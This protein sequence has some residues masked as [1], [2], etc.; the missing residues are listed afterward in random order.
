MSESTPNVP[1]DAGD[2]VMEMAEDGDDAPTCVVHAM[3]Q[4]R[5]AKARRMSALDVQSQMKGIAMEFA[6]N[7]I[8]PDKTIQLAERR[9]SAKRRRSSARV[10]FI[11]KDTQDKVELTWKE[12]VLKNFLSRTFLYALMWVIWLIVG[13]IFYCLRLNL[14]VSKGF[15]QSV[16]VGYS[17]GWGDISEIAS[18]VQLFSTIYVCVG[19]SFVGAGLGFFAEGVVADVDNW[20]VNAQQQAL[21]DLRQERTHSWIMVTVYWFA[22]HWEKV[23]AILLWLGFIIIGTAVACDVNDWP[24]ITGLYFSTSSL[25]TGGLVALPSDADD[26]TYGMLGLYGALGIPLMAL[27]MGTLAGFFINVGDIEDTYNDMKQPVTDE[28]L[29]ILQD[30]DLVDDDGQLDRLEFIILCMVRMGTDPALIH[31][32]KGYFDEVDENGDGKLSIEELRGA[33][34][35]KN[36]TNSLRNIKKIHALGVK[37]DNF[38]HPV[39]SWL[40]STFAYGHE[41]HEHKEAEHEEAEEPETQKE[42]QSLT[43]HE[44]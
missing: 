3:D 4:S 12:E 29:E 19:A 22:F 43:A 32:I 40:D 21:Y 8:I 5:E 31:G 27:A 23:R 26:W 6:N 28:E 17:V 30:L 7:G 2:I 37:V 36:K 14:T 34:S 39:V 1:S 20:Y 42:E 15:Y 10:S 25:S 18:E 35:K 13:T 16:N 11:S 33:A 41:G 38:H 44:V 9:A 24:F